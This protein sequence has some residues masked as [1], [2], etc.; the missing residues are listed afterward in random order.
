M[1]GQAC[2]RIGLLGC[3][4]V[5]GGVVEAL[6]QNRERIHQYAG[7]VPVIHRIAV[8]DAGKTRHPEVKRRQLCTDWRAV[9]E[10]G[11]VDVVIEVMGGIEPARSAILAALCAGK[12]VITANKQLLALHGPELMECAHRHGATLHYEASVLAGIPA[13]HTLNT[14]FFANRVRRLRGIVNGTSNYI[15]TRMTEGQSFAE[16]L[17]EA[18]SLGYAEA[19]PSQDINGDDALYKLQVLIWT[20]TGQPLPSA[21]IRKR[22]IDV[23]SAQEV[24]EAKRQGKRWKLVAEAEFDAAGNPVLA[25]VEPIALAVDDPL[26]HVDGVA[27]ALSI[28]G[29]LVGS[30]TLMGPG[31]GAL[32][33]ASAIVEDLLQGLRARPSRCPRAEMAERGKTAGWDNRLNLMPV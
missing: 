8:R 12:P 30:V 25:T 20:L 13:I 17:A 21:L 32:P 10:D 26:Y 29:D 14:Y 19:N 22:G 4:V 24:W 16:A 5:G 27:N 6:A 33:T 15:L 9:V 3:G 7:V 23:L 1:T 28:E 18:Q 2:V 11:E 31:A